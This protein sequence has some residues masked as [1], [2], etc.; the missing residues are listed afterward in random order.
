LK[1]LRELLERAVPPG[2]LEAARVLRAWRE[3]AQEAGLAPE[4]DYRAGTLVV[5]VGTSSEAQE[6]AL[7]AETLRQRVNAHL[8]AEV[9][10]AVR[11]RCG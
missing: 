8:G 5:R 3:V 9:V 6:V 7:R 2:V 1:S 11:A 10:R 4:A